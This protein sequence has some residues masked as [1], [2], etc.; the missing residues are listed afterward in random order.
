MLHSIFPIRKQRGMGFMEFAIVT[1]IIII[2]IGTITYKAWLIMAE[3][4]RVGMLQILNNIRFNLTLNVLNKEMT[5]NLAKINQTDCLNPMSFM[6]TPPYK[7]LGSFA[8]PPPNLAAGNWY[9][10]TS[11]CQ[12][13]YQWR[14]FYK[15]QDLYIHPEV[16][17]FNV[18][19]IYRGQQ[20]DRRILQN[21][22]LEAAN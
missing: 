20:M 9:F 12:L 13:V 4:E 8:E 11:D 5:G 10:D 21:L 14:F 19:K 15:L 3:S 7:Y 17:R 2:L 6:P 22:V 16:S 18:K 1:A